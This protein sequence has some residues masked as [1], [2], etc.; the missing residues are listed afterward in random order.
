M[1]RFVEFGDRV[2]ETKED[3]LVGPRSADGLSCPMTFDYDD[4]RRR[5]VMIAALYGPLEGPEYFRGEV[6]GLGE[7]RTFKVSRVQCLWLDGQ[8][9]TAQIGWRIG[10]A[11]RQAHGLPAIA[12][13]YSIELADVPIFLRF[14]ETVYDFDEADLNHVQER[15]MVR[16]YEGVAKRL[17]L[18]YRWD[19][20]RHVLTVSGRPLDGSKRKS[21]FRVAT[22]GSRVVESIQSK[23]SG[24]WVADWVTWLEQCQRR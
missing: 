7:D 24:E 17:T 21:T 10:H 2:P 6:Q 18:E 22:Y 9:H 19:G 13:P 20:P 8:A 16:E 23:I 5:T 14:S 3:E 15:Q 11:I 4:G 1:A 12:A